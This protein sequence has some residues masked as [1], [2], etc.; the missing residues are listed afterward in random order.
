MIPLFAAS[1]SWCVYRLAASLFDRRTGW[2]AAVLAALLPAFYFRMGEFRTDVMW[3]TVW[4]LTLVVALTGR[5]TPGRIFAAA[6]LLGACFSVSMKTTYL[7]FFL[8]IAGTITWLL[9]GR[10][11]S[12]SLPSHILALVGGVLIVPGAIVAYFASRGALQPLYHCVI[13]HNTASGES[14]T[15]SI[16]CSQA[17]RFG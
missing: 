1:H 16:T 14:T 10:P 8:A 15:C 2:F 5:M 3:V 13:E 11:I 7:V 12:K 4:L 17:A 9:A 6:L